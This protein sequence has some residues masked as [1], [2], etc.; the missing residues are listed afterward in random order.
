MP[1]PSTFRRSTVVDDGGRG[2]DRICRLRV[3]RPASP[4]RKRAMHSHVSRF[5]VFALAAAALAAPARAWGP[6]EGAAPAAPDLGVPDI[7]FT[8]K[9]LG[10]GL[11]VIVHED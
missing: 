5:V 7:P 6:P 11:T 9:V 1:W 4:G 3:R 2:A 10:N 8:K